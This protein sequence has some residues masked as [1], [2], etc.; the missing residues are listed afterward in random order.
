M[1]EAKARARERLAALERQRRERERLAEEARSRQRQRLAGKAARIERERAS[2]QPALEAVGRVGAWRNRNRVVA[3]LEDGKVPP[4]DAYTAAI[5]FLLA[6]DG[7]HAEVEEAFAAR[8]LR[9]VERWWEAG[10]EE[11]SKTLTAWTGV[12][13]LLRENC[14]HDIADHVVVSVTFEEKERFRSV[15]FPETAG[16]PARIHPDA[17]RALDHVPHGVLADVI[18]TGRMRRIPPMIEA[19]V[20]AAGE[21]FI[22]S[23]VDY[24]NAQFELR[25]GHGLTPVQRNAVT[26]LEEHALRAV[27]R[28]AI[29]RGKVGPETRKVY[30]LVTETVRKADCWLLCDLPFRR[31]GAAGD[32]ARLGPQ[33][34]T[35]RQPPRRSG[36]A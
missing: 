31:V 11:E 1:E 17:M 9:D 36:A 5:P 20:R 35:S 15:V 8:L 21:P 6:G 16:N 28:A 7:K 29:G 24:F 34:H 30:D 10:I 33:P 14:L 4:L 13:A 2:C 32:R 3:A 12:A 25:R 26:P 18:A 27:K 23:C 19:A 22:S